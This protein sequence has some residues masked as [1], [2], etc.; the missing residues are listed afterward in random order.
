[1]RSGVS[2]NGWIAEEEIG[3]GEEKEET[4][5]KEEKLER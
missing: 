2:M 4:E 5:E 1:M 3:S